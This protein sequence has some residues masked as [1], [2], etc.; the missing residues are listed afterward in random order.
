MT[1][2]PHFCGGGEL[3]SEGVSS[4]APSFSVLSK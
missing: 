4:D 3:K 1:H 2:S